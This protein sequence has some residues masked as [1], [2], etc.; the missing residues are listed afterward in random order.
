KILPGLA[1]LRVPSR[2]WFI[3]ALSVAILAAYGVERLSVSISQASKPQILRYA[4]IGIAV[5]ASLDLLRASS[6]L[7]VAR[8]LPP[9]TPAT[10]WL[11]AQP[12]RFRVFAPRY[13]LPQPDTLQHA[14]GIDPLYLANY[15]DFM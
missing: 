1:F 5:I 11:T 14:D 7:L 12:G 10:A 4:L 13:N 2:A 9:T 8:P 6:A 3:V 15:A